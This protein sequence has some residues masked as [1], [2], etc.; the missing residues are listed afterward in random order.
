MR[1]NMFL[2]NEE[3]L[4]ELVN[5][6]KETAYDFDNYRV[7]YGTEQ[8][9]MEA[10]KDCS[11]MYIEK[12]ILRYLQEYDDMLKIHSVIEDVMDYDK[13]ENEIYNKAIPDILY[14]AVYEYMTYN[15][16]YGKYKL[17]DEDYYNIVISSVRCVYCTEKMLDGSNCFSD[18]FIE[19]VKNKQ[20]RD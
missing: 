8:L 2:C 9:L 14:R 7:R 19:T 11:D 6:L 15:K 3:E 5:T 10:Y 12:N 1:K 13:D 4:M 16:R 20:R 18:K 17:T